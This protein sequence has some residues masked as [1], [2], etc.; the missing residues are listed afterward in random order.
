MYSL[1]ET[2][3]ISNNFLEAN[4]ERKLEQIDYFKKMVK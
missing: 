1:K 4:L 2:C 3:K